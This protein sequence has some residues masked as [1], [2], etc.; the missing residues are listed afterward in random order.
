MSENIEMLEIDSMDN[1]WDVDI[2][3]MV[4]CV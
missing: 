1:Q 2:H 3:V 4:L